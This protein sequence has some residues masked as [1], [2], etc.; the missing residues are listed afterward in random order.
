MNRELLQLKLISFLSG[1]GIG[2]ASLSGYLLFRDNPLSTEAT[3]IL[4]TF[5]AVIGVASW[6]YLRDFNEP[7]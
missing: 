2:M 3:A 5:S 6:M 1:F 4:M 7:V